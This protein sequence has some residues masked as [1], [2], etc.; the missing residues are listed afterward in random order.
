MNF[1]Q[2]S[3]NKFKKA[4]SVRVLNFQFLNVFYNNLKIYKKSKFPK[5]NP[6]SNQVN[7]CN[8]A[9]VTSNCRNNYGWKNTTEI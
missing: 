7:N 1:K 5:K 4:H 2:K 9:L 8:S 3:I 6:P